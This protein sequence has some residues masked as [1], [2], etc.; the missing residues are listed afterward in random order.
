MR[1]VLPVQNLKWCFKIDQKYEF[2]LNLSTV[3]FFSTESKVKILFFHFFHCFQYSTI[4][5]HKS[6][7]FFKEY[8]SIFEKKGYLVFWKTLFTFTTIK[9]EEKGHYSYFNKVLFYK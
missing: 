3:L 6:G 4:L 9:Y 1:I 2:T 7:M 5:S 8:L